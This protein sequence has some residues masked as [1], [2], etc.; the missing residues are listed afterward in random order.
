[1]AETCVQAS[2]SCRD[3]NAAR[4]SRMMA[5]GFTVLVTAI[6]LAPL[7]TFLA[8]FGLVVLALLRGSAMKI[9]SAVTQLRAKSRAKAREKGT[10]DRAS[11]PVSIS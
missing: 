6:I 5:A 3:W 10:S 4:F 11:D 2:E 1:M 7:A 9:A 8:L